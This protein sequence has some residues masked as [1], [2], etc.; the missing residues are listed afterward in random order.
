MRQENTVPGP[1]VRLSRT[2]TARPRPGVVLVAVI[3]VFTICLTLFGLWART[4]I[5]HQQQLRQQQFRLQSVRL[6]EAG[7]RR[8]VIRHSTDRA[9]TGEQWRVPARQLDKRHSA[10][11]RI[12]VAAGT[13]DPGGVRIRATSDYPSNGLKRARITRTVEISLQATGNET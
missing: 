13:M 1:A 8:A 9:F 4:A 12:Q 11:V 5:Q 10:E 7:L 3:V 6:A 2:Q